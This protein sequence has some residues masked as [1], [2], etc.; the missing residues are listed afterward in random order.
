MNPISLDAAVA[1]ARALAHPA[2]LRTVA[3]L[4]AGELCVCQITAILEL[5]PSTVSAHLKEL[6]SAGLTTERRSGK[7]VHVRIS[8][9]PTAR[10]WVK[11]ALDAAEGDPQ[12]EADAQLLHRLL[13]VPVEE[14]CR[15]GRDAVVP[16]TAAIRG[17]AP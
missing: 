3:I 2:R 8:D 14:L 13:S 4:R 5:A 12:L 6:R 15:R 10:A 9:H 11:T 7:W 1:A 16:E 17:S